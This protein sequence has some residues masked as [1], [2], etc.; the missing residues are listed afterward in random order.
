M[1]KTRTTMALAGIG[2]ATALAL[3]VGGATLANAASESPTSTA[4]STTGSA[5]PSQGPTQGSTGGSSGTLPGGGVQVRSGQGGA[6]DGMPGGGHGGPRDDGGK[7]TADAAAKAVTAAEAKV[8]GGT[9]SSV[10]ATST[11]TYVV[12]VLK[13]DGTEV[14]VLLDAKFA[15]TSVEEGGMAGRG[16]PAGAP[17]TGTSSGSSDP[18]DANGT[19]SGTT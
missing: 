12:D 18:S 1:E 13:S 9:A 5:A 4:T 11:G 10:R 2:V 8:S 14:H 15:V 16:G 3:G 17:P 19:S 7:L 6:P